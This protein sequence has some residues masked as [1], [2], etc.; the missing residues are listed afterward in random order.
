MLRDVARGLLDLAFPPVCRLCAVP[1]A[2]GGDLCPP[3]RDEL[4]LDPYSTCPRCGSSLGAGVVPAAKCAD[5]RGESYAFDRVYRVG[6]YEG[7]RRE[8]I[9]RAKRDESAAECAARVFAESIGPKLAGEGV[10]VVSAV[11]LHWYRSWR[12]QYNQ[13]V[14]F[15][16][17]LAVRLRVP[18]AARSLRRIRSTPPQTWLTPTARRQNVRGAFRARG[19]QLRGKTV[20]LV[21]DVLTTG[22]TADATAQALKQAGAARVIVA[23]LAHG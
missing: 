8:L 13:S 11:P 15:A 6:R 16:R 9:L 4:L 1:L 21:D 19:E 10:E 5:C 14:L 3:C 2:R 12:R 20:A 18:L 23:V 17:E 22:A 7:R